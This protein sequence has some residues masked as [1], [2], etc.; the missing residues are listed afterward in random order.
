MKISSPF[1]ILTLIL[2]SCEPDRIEPI[3]DCET[4]GL[5]ITVTNV[6]GSSCVGADGSISVAGS[7]GKAPYKF[8]ISGSAPVSDSIFT[9]LASGSY[10]ITI[11]DVNNCFSNAEATV[12]NSAGF[13]INATS[14]ETSCTANTGSITIT[15]IGGQ[16][17]FQYKLGAGNFGDSN[18]FENLAEGNYN[19][20]SKDANQCQA[21]TQVSVV[22]A[23]NL[24][25]S[26]SVQDAGCGTS[27]GRVTAN[28]TGGVGPF[29]YKLGNG[30][31][32]S[33]NTF[34]NLSA[35]SYNVTVKDA[36]GCTESGSAK[37]LSGVKFSTSIS[38]IISTNCATGSCHG[39][40]QS[41]N[42]STFDAIKQNAASIKSVTANGSMPKNGSLSQAQ[43]DAIACW[44]NDGA[45][46]N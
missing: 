15:T 23:G 42:L 11:Q 36:E 28:V 13:T 25:I 6:V 19:V 31:F 27:N 33:S 3:I 39:G 34:S 5:S 21:S 22:K 24:A 32:G 29:E 12:N 8:S 2:F 45:P 1:L 37:V 38:S 10:T 43:I 44:V 17:P 35:N 4:S 30:T 7:G 40:S 46:N 16:A 26:L 14:E 18:T 41:P 20:T 9:N